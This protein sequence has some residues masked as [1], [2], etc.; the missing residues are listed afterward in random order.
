MWQINWICSLSSQ[1]TWNSRYNTVEIQ[2]SRVHP[3]SSISS[4]LIGAMHLLSSISSALIGAI[5][6]LSSISSALIGG[7]GLC[8]C[9]LERRHLRSSFW[10]Q[11]ARKIENFVAMNSYEASLLMFLHYGGMVY[12]T[13]FIVFVRHCAD[14]L[15]C[16]DDE[17][18]GRRIAFIFYLVPEWTK[19]DGGE[20]NERS[21][22]ATTCSLWARVT[23]CACMYVC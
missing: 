5:H 3:L 7:H 2:C 21:V 16:H 12:H 13:T 17:L 19:E 4:A 10:N 22:T 15:L 9:K 18:E 8:D 20:M 6:L 23:S 1:P 14:V 11:H